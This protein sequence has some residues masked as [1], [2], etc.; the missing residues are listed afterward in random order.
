MPPES[1]KDKPKPKG[2][3]T[4]ALQKRVSE[5]EGENTKLRNLAVVLQ[6]R[7]D[8]LTQQCAIS[9]ADLTISA[10]NLMTVARNPNPPVQPTKEIIKAIPKKG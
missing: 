7:V 9:S 4:K 6:R 2:E 1:E 8:R 3:N 5:L 10:A